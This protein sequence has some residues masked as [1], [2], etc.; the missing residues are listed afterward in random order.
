MPLTIRTEAPK[1]SNRYNLDP[2]VRCIDELQRIAQDARDD[3]LGDDWAE[4]TKKF[5]SMEGMLGKAP[6]FRPQIQI[7]QLQVLALSE[8]QDLSDVS[9]QVYIYDKQ[10][11]N[12]DDQRS[13]AFMEQWK[14]CWVNY[15]LMFA[16]LWAQFCGIG[17]IQC[18]YD[19][20]GDNGFGLCWARHR[21]PDTVFVDQGA[22]TMSR[23]DCTYSILE[24][25]FYPDQVAYNWPETGAGMRAEAIMPGGKNSPATLPGVPHKMRFPDGPMRM[26]GSF[27]DTDEIQSDGRLRVRYLFIDDRTIEAVREDAGSDSAAIVERGTYTKRLRYPNMRLIVSVS[28]T[29]GRV[30]ADGDNPIPGGRH[31][32]V[33]VYGL[34]PLSGFYPPPPSRYTRDLQLYVERLMTQI[35]ENVVRLNNGCWFID[36]GT[37]INTDMFGGLPGEVQVINDQS[38]VPTL[39]M[40][41]ALNQQVLQLAQYLLGLQKELQGH[42]QSREG[43]PGAGNI[44]PELFE[45]SIYQSQRLT[46][47]RARLLAKSVDEI[48]NTLFDLMQL[49]YTQPR[50]YPTNEGGFSIATWKPCYGIGSRDIKL[51]I[52][53]SS[54]LPISQAAM[55]QMVPTLRQEGMIDV[56]TGLEALGVPDAQGIADRLMREQALAALQ[57]I[58]R[59]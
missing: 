9:P 53:P 45:A 38:R 6:S 58:G 33:P 14:S 18:G 13:R 39:V 16:T 51:H 17:F 8:A 21:A 15:H 4:Q 40:P 36:K 10:T 54:L 34:P 19:P 41:N 11:G 3:Y 49:N 28:G 30:V 35:F 32:V 1:S 27:N 56:K 26:Q 43:V 23:E 37:G 47:M 55:R 24:D 20:F 57:K 52:D 22:M 48:A 7:P 29:N 50:V 5:Y 31:A 2:R 44:S 12:K 25:R 59:R 46:R 42:T